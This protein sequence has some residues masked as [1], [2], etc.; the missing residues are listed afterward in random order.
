MNIKACLTS[1]NQFWKT[2]KNIYEYYMKNNYFDPCPVDPT[3]DGLKIKWKK[4]NFVNPPYNEV[5]KWIDKSIAESKKGNHVIMLIPARTDTKW[6]RTLYENGCT[7]LF[8]QGRLK[9]ND[10][11]S[12]PFPSMFVILDKYLKGVKCHY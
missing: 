1:K 5:H 11:N 4:M 2:P 9:F 10:S 12:A 6:F 7:I 8:I 3:F